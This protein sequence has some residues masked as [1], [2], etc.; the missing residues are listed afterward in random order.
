MRVVNGV[1]ATVVSLALMLGAG[2]AAWADPGGPGGSGSAA[3]ALPEGWELSRSGPKLELVWRAPR[4]LPVGA[5]LVEFHA[6][7]RLL[8]W[9]VAAP[10]GRTFRLVIDGAAARDLTGLK[11]LAAGRRLDMVEAPSG[12]RSPAEARRAAAQQLPPNPVDPGTPG[13]Y[14]TIS[15]EYALPDLSLPGF[16]VPVEMRGFVVAPQGTTGERPLVLFLT[17]RHATCYQGTSQTSLQ[18][19]CPDGWTSL[20]SHR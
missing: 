17:G 4:P 2:Q 15:G 14:S 18:W 1:V 10:D 16:A 8:G 6:G 7:D 5:A 12:S 20:P 9:P 19:P 11:V 3:E 13:P